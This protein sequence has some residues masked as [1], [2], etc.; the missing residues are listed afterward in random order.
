MRPESMAKYRTIQAAVDQGET[1][2]GAC[3]EHGLGVPTFYAAQKIV[4]KE[5]RQAKKQPKMKA[6]KFVDLP[7]APA[8][9]KVAL[10]VC[11]PGQIAAIIAGLK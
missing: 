8:V 1:V 4:A 6:M 9:D 11:E 10:I 7:A 2:K 5:A 3:K